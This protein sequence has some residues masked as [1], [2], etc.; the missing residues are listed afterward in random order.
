MYKEV[1]QERYSNKGKHVEFASDYS[2]CHLGWR[3]Y[4]RQLHLHVRKYVKKAHNRI[5]QPAVG[6]A[7]LIPRART[8]DQKQMD[9][10]HSQ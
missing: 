4:L 5:P 7:L 2:L 8:L 9:S 10:N 1:I 6:Q 3:I